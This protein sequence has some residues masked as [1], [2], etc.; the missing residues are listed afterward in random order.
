MAMARY[1]KLMTEWRALSESL[2]SFGSNDVVNGDTLGEM[3][4]IQEAGLVQGNDGNFYGSR[5]P[6]REPR[7]SCRI[8]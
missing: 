4:G 8:P 5:H 6:R 2:Y 7:R 3:V 1:S